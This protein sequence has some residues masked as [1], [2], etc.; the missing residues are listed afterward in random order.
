M[1][2]WHTQDSKLE[3]REREPLHLKYHQKNGQNGLFLVIL[4]KIPYFLTPNYQKM[5]KNLLINNDCVLLKL[6]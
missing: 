6:F 2:I 4:P 1:H 3:Q 5:G